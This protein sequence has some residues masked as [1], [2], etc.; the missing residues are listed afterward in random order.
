MIELSG[1]RKVFA[2]PQGKEVVAVS[3]I[4]FRVEKGETLCL[5]GPSGCGKTTTLK[6]INRL[7]EPSSGTIRIDGEDVTRFDPIELRRGIGYVIQSGGLFPHMTVAQN[8][9]LLCELD[10]WDGQRI[11]E[12][13]HELL[14][15]VNLDPEEL[16]ER[17]PAEISGG[18]RQRVGVARSLAL[19]P[20]T[21]LM[22]E[23]FGALDP[24]TRDQ[25]HGEFERLESIVRKTVIMVTHDMAEAFRLGDRVALMDQGIL[26]QVG[27]ERDFRERP[28]TPFVDEFLRQHLRDDH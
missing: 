11:R 27:N 23:P 25:I 28:A 5:I 14:E 2:D 13:V 8:I 16:S 9:G 3:G 17:Y 21:I 4:D 24:I 7:L 6:M 15:L 26:V 1:V 12:R 10:G 18:Q 20:D 19:D 22:D